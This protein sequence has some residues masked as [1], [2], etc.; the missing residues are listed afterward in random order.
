[1]EFKSLINS[2]DLLTSVDTSLRNRGFIGNVKGTVKKGTKKAFKKVEQTPI[3][4]YTHYSEEN[5]FDFDIEPV[6]N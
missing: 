5:F 1:M 4:A 3:L 2:G 6:S